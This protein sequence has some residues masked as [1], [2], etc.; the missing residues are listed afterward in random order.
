MAIIYAEEDWRGRRD[1]NHYREATEARGDS[2]D[3]DAYIPKPAPDDENFAATPFLKSF[4]LQPD[5]PILTSDLFSFV[6]GHIAQT[7]LARDT[8]HRH[9]TDLVAWQIASDALKAGKLDIGR[10]FG[11]DDTDPAA[12]AAAAGTV[13][14]GLKPDQ[15][16]FE[17]LRAASAREFSR[18]PLPYGS[19][20][21]VNPLPAH[22]ARV[23]DVCKRLEL[24]AC[25]ELALGG[26]DEAL[27]DV[28][29]G[30]SLADSIKLEPFLISYRVRVA[31]L[32]NAIQ[33]VWEGLAGHRWSDAQLQELQARFSSYDFLADIQLPL[34]GERAA[35]ARRIDY[36][37]K[38]GVGIVDENFP[39]Y[40]GAQSPFSR[41]V[42]NLIGRV[43]P[44]GWYYQEKLNYCTMFDAQ[45]KGMVDRAAKQ[46]SP[47]KAQSNANELARQIGGQSDSPFK[48]ILHH[49]FLAPMQLLFLGREGIDA[50]IPQTY[51]NQA[52]LACA[53]E[54]YRLVT[55]Q[56]PETL[57]L[58][59]PQFLSRLPKDVIGG[60]P[61][62]Y[63]RTTD[64]Q[65]VL[66]SVGWNEKDDG[67][68]PGNTL[69]DETQG[70]WVW[71][72][73]AN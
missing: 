7:N 70:D 29:L 13:L 53:L 48:A 20:G 45:S 14:E 31:C 68:V 36:I 62:K 18:Y 30:L 40:H 54:R 41:N 27:A 24:E 11:T 60:Q 6:E 66:Y 67:G 71:S 4:V 65:I 34:K 10:H 12:R 57:E 35:E 47:S 33:P 59:T 46:V 64:G 56:F 5:Q 25:A 61:Y 37:E 28:K 69:F 52:A 22:L 58:L 8:G 72:Y 16:V 32:L 26:S 39:Y 73:P 3:F 17:E 50:A 44:S 55:G 38:S 23:Q 9:F 49:R 1:W 2:L 42:L 63:R 51:A 21:P 43:M 19:E 15:A